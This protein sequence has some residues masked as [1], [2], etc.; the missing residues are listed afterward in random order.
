M[1]QNMTHV[2][3]VSLNNAEVEL[4]EKRE[5]KYRPTE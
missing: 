3:H 1:Y 5:K 4:K 2:R